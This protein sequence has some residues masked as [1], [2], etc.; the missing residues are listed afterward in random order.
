M[1]LTEGRPKILFLDIETQPDLVWVW[2]VYEQNAI[3]VKEHWQLLSFSASWEEGKILTKGLP[4]YPGYKPGGTDAALVNEVWGLLDEADIVVAHNG[5]DF[6]L[7][8]LNARF[9]CH[10]LKPPSPY[11]VVDTKRAV[12]RVAAFSSNKLDW[13]CKQLELGS[14]LVHEG[15]QLWFNCMQGDPAAWKKM[16]RY[17]QHDVELLKE[18][19]Y[20]L[21]PWI[22][23]PT[24]GNWLSGARCPNPACGSTK[25]ERRGLAHT[26]TRVYQRFQCK[27]C[28]AWS[29]AVKADKARAEIIPC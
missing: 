26:K 9:I 13:L 7:K 8:K 18:L 21:A 28:G 17:N 25:L 29:R 6:D 20:E 2:G 1:P 4:D 14:K 22:V 23:Q 12:K 10:G 5:A 3:S 11:K 19:Y 15:W 27:V 24:M 16:K